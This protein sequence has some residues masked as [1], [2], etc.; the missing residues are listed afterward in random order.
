[1][2][3]FKITDASDISP[4]KYTSNVS[5]NINI[6]EVF[7]EDEVL[8]LTWNPIYKQIQFTIKT[9]G[10]I[11]RGFNEHINVNGNNTN[12]FQVSAVKNSEYF[13]SD[14]GETYNPTY[15]YN[16]S[17][18]NALIK[19]TSINKVKIPLYNLQVN[20]FSSLIYFNVLK[21]YQD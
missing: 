13:F 16:L 8:L 3:N 2:Q 11:I 15:N 14:S 9:S 12:A 7:Y 10:T 20:S 6:L 4:G 21:F 1:M 19:F 5:G 17:W 18:N